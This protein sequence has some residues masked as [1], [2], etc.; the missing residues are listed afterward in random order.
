MKIL[1]F[2]SIFL[3]TFLTQILQGIV[4]LPVVVKLSRGEWLL[5]SEEELLKFTRFLWV[6]IILFLLITPFLKFYPFNEKTGLWF[7]EGFFIFRNLLVLILFYIFIELYRLKRKD[8]YA[9]FYLFL[10]VLSQ[11]LIAFDIILPLEYPFY[12]TLLGGYFFMET[13][14]MGLCFNHFIISKKINK[15]KIDSLHKNSSMIFGFSLAWAGLLFTQFLVIWYG[16]I[17]EEVLYLSKRVLYTPYRELSLFVLLFCF[18]IPFS[19]LALK[20]TKLNIKFMNF[21]SIL[22]ILGILIEKLILILPSLF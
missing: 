16:N 5:E 9:I 3:F 6:P 4:T 8:T 10:F 19:T 18:I 1:A 17:G 20:K 12:S 11:S 22:V 14:Y 2:L 7:N 21:I 15:E 13:F